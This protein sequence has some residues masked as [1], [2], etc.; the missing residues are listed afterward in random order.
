VDHSRQALV[1]ESRTEINDHWKENIHEVWVDQFASNY[2]FSDSTDGTVPMREFSRVFNPKSGLFWEAHKMV[3]SLQ[4]ITVDETPLITPTVEFEATV[5]AARAMSFAL[6][7]GGGEAVSVHFFAT[8]VRGEGVVDV[9]LNL[10]DQALAFYD[11]PS[12]RGE[13]VLA[14][15]NTKGTKLEIRVGGRQG[16]VSR[17][18]EGGDWAFLRLV[19]EGKPQSE[20]GRT[21]RMKW[22]IQADVLGKKQTYQVEAILEADDEKNPFHRGFFGGLRMP[23]MV[24]P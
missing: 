21:F 19:E 5:E 7:G 2:P 16:W 24:C 14:E 23:E 18:P 9:K 4:R 17:D 20:D 22:D 11:N 6:Y 10:G 15:G 12:H 1:N 8:L 3:L 13:M